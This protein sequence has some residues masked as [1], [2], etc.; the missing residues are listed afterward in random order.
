LPDLPGDLRDALADRYTIER[1]LGRGGMAT[2]YLAHDLKHD[3]DVALKVLRPEL[4]TT[5]GPERFLREIQVTAKLQHPHILP[6]FDSGT[7]VGQLWYS[8]PYVEGESLRSRLQREKQ[9]SL[10]TALQIIRQVLGALGYAHD[11]GV[12]HRDIKPENILLTGDQ[13]VVADFGIANAISTA[14][15][16]RLTETGLAV[17]TAAYMSPEQAAGERSL[18]GRTDLYAVGCVLYEMLAAEP[19]FTGP[20]PQAVIAKR[21]S[22]PP[23]HL[24]TLRDVP[25][26]LELA[27]TR[28]LARASVD[29]FASAQDFDR[30]L[31]PSALSQPVVPAQVVERAGPRSKWLPLVGAAAIAG[32]LATGIVLGR[33]GGLP[34]AGGGSGMLSLAVLPL[35]NLSANADQDYFADGMTD[36]L[37]SDLSALPNFRV[38]SR[39]SV[40]QYKGVKKSVAEIAK[41]L[42]VDRIVEGTILRAG[43]EVRVTAALL[44]PATEQNL[45]SQSYRHDLHD[46]L[47][48]QSGVAHDIAREVA[49]RLSPNAAVH[50]AKDRS[51]DPAAHEDYLMGR[52]FWNSRSTEGLTKAFDYYQRAVRKDS[53]YALA[54]TGIANY[55]NALAFYTR[56]S[57]SDAFPKAKAAALK[58]IA[59]DDSLAEA[60]GALAFTLAYFDWDW[61]AAERE[62][63]RA[64]AL[65][66]SDAG[67]HHS[68]SRYLA[69]TDRTEEAI[70]ELRRAQE[71]DPLSVVLKANEGMVLYFAGRYDDAIQQLR[72]TLTLDPNHPVAH[73]GLG[74]CFEQKGL[75]DDAAKEIEKASEGDEPD[76]NFMASL[77]HVYAAQGKVA[78][79]R[80]LLGR[81][82]EE[83]KKYYVSPYFSAVLHA[84]LGE[85][86][87]A[88]EL[89]TKAADERSTLLVYLKK[90]PRLTTLH[91]DPRFGAL[92]V[93][94]GLGA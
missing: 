29:R 80:R 93:R 50:L 10:E 9:L 27:V 4:A 38:I 60:H 21:F 14:G 55:Y 92:L 16:E 5:L 34:A 65:N 74:L 78:E 89:L 33:R 72:K 58:A 83:S 7:T 84:A 59:L 73:W 39:R 87:K 51:V 12:V 86:D 40:M 13:A 3:R 91:S 63:Q 88:F 20:T 8:M 28:A 79:V 85:N 37:I 25:P 68:Y 2:V 24:R 52:F 22:E 11:H 66:P 44:D 81:M 32:L 94:I 75:Y 54:Y 53:T 23:P 48:L 76:P 46:V 15:G 70:A 18:D 6:L 19:P 49:S 43:D 1:E 31:S 77:G 17:G 56:V 62:F 47:A 90:D 42:G 64:L 30:A 69:S 26:A 45:W 82:E 61:A 67:V 41:A 35:E 57:P 71:L 36:A